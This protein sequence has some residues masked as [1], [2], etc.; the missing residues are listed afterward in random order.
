[1]KSR[2]L[3]VSSANVDFVQRMERVPE[4]GETI[5]E[6]E[7]GY[8]YIPG[9]KGANAA[10]TFARLGADCVFCAKVGNDAN[11]ARLRQLY[12]TEGIDVRFLVSD[13]TLSTGLASILVEADG[14]NRIMVYPGANKNL[15]PSDV[16][17]AFTSYPDALFLQF[18]IPD[19]AIFAAVK[20]AE[21]HQ[22]PVFIDAAP[23]RADFPLD[24]LKKIEIFSLNETETEIF[25]G[26]RPTTAENCLRASI[27]FSTMLNVR[28]IVLKLGKRGSYLYDGKYYRTVPS[29]DVEAVDTTAAGDIYTAALTHEYLQT[30]DIVRA[31]NFATA[32]AAVSVS[33]PG[34]SSSV[35]TRAEVVRFLDEKGVVLKGAM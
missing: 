23:A 16:E 9:G 19:K 20:F 25:T 4:P 8:T 22:I 7:G 2:I 11:G 6:T 31:I 10:V 33:R 27:R 28:Y 13:R 30:Q 21:E 32:A 15:A 17:E 3:V 24:A 34:A 18:E 1:M 14:S 26:I 5:I 12:S 29:Y 35:P